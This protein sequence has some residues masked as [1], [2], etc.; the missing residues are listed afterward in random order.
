MRSVKIKQTLEFTFFVDD[1]VTEE[2]AIAAGNSILA[3]DSVPFNEYE[4]IEAEITIE[5]KSNVIPLFK[6][7]FVFIY[8]PPKIFSLKIY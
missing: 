5:N 3:T 6:F 4:M 7:S 1:E 8:I 2:E